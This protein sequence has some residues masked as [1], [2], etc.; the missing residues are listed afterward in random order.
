MSML[1][2]NKKLLLLFFF[3]IAI[4]G[5]V[6]VFSMPV[7]SA[8]DNTNA[9]ISDTKNFNKVEIRNDGTTMIQGKPFFPFGFYHVSW[10]STIEELIGDLQKIAAAGFNTIHASA[11][12]ISDYSRFLEEAEKLGIYTISESSIEK[13]DL[14]NFLKHKPAVL[15][16][17]IADDV[18]N[19]RLSTEQVWE[20]HHLV[21]KADPNHVTYISGYTDKITDF[22]NCAEVIGVQ[23]Y[24]IPIEKTKS[25]E[26]AT[27]E[28]LSTAKKETDLFNHALYANVQAFAWTDANNPEY[29]GARS[30]TSNEVRNMTYQALLGGAKGII[31]YTFRDRVWDLTQQSDL[32]QGIR[33]LVP[34]IK[35]LSPAFLE[36][37]LTKLNTQNSDL[38]AGQWTYYDKVYVVVLN[39]SQTKTIEASI[40]IHATTISLAEP[41]FAKRPHGLVLKDG[42]LTG[43]IKPG[44]VHVYHL[45]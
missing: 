40:P 9:F 32:W 14:I 13:L 1:S 27:Y 21:K 3:V 8:C 7:K 28:I 6:N 20:A 37:S 35:L 42:K 2:N 41:L 4:I 5:S 11:T 30:P 36:G 33:S 29:T 45:F 16:W 38:L 25:S 17:N 22:A 34:E 10:E 44:D 31:Y 43:T 15:G 26:K 19:G 39:V 23:S 18:D 24:P 12:N